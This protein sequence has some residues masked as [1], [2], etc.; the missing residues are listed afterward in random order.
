M[1]HLAR[2]AQRI[3]CDVAQIR[4]QGGT[5]G[6]GLPKFGGVGGK[7]GDVYITGS[8]KVSRLEAVTRHRSCKNGWFQAG[9]GQ[10]ALRTRLLGE[11]G[12]D[13]VI[14]VPPGVTVTDREGKNLGEI[15]GPQDKISVALGG[16]G[17]DKY[18]DGHGFMGQKQALRLD[19]KLISDAVL[20]GFPNA[21]KS[22][23]LNSISAAKPKV[24]DYPFTTLK[25]TLGMLRYK[26]H[27][28]ISL[29]D[30]PGLIEGAHKNI[31]LGY[32]FL[33]HIVRASL[34]VF[35]IDINGVDLN[36]SHSVRQPLEA[37]TILNKEIE[38]YDDTILRKPAILAVNKIDSMDPDRDHMQRYNRLVDEY[39]TLQESGVDS[40]REEIRPTNLIQFRNILPISAKNSLG[41]NPLKECIRETLDEIAE[42]ERL[43]REKFTS[44]AE[45]QESENNRLVQ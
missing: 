22:M 12:H 39:K 23:L 37:V 18:N 5:G 30:L 6:T 41:M 40:L 38:L 43:E 29:A 27:R 20:V 42:A 31:G 7:G 24:A 2:R 10:P 36:T 45:I 3:F 14:Q 1:N 25:P 16:R 35:V 21:G 44:F 8:H 32:E 33:K 19:F 26:D 28:Q 4:V 9:N 11:P 34:L 17:G 15:N 13:L